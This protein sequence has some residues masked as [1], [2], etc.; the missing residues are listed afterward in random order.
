MKP[1]TE[2]CTEWSC[3]YH[4]GDNRFKAA[5]DDGCPVREYTGFVLGV[6][7]DLEAGDEPRVRCTC[8]S[9]EPAPEGDYDARV[10]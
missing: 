5:H 7:D 1:N 3:M 4:G 6:L 10:G 8:P 2:G 9:T